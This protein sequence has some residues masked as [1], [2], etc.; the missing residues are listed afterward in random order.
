MA[1]RRE[2]ERQALER[3]EAE[4]QEKQA[5][6]RALFEAQILSREEFARGAGAKPSSP[7]V[8]PL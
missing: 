2:Q 4:R 8:R 5:R 1:G 6:E 3:L 7:P